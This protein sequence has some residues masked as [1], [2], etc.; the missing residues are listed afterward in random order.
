MSYGST[1]KY[2]SQIYNR[3]NNKNGILFVEGMRL[4]NL[5][6]KFTFKLLVELN[7]NEIIYVF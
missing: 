3:K 7:K 6:N 2:S 4:Y 5:K 1:A